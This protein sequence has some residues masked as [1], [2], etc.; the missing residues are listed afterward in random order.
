MPVIMFTFF[1]L[2]LPPGIDTFAWKENHP[3][4]S[5]KL[6]AVNSQRMRGRYTDRGEI[7]TP[8]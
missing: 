6:L 2:G 3:L 8:R 5:R 4:N 7:Y 1:V